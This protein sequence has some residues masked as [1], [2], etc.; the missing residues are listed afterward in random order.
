L[1]AKSSFDQ[2]IL[3]GH[4]SRKKKHGILTILVCV[5]ALTVSCDDEIVAAKYSNLEAARQ[6]GAI[7]KGWLPDNLPG[8]SYQ[9]REVHVIDTGETWGEV[10]FP[11]AERA[12]FEKT[13]LQ[14]SDSE[15][16]GHDLSAAPR[17][18]WW[19]KFLTGKLRAQT[20]R[21]QGFGAYSSKTHVFWF[22]VSWTDGHAYFW[23]RV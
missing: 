17:G 15:L 5:I 18:D 3:V 16:D 19:P 22:A 10:R 9:V 8:G 21:D 20:L 2:F 6:A 7:D 14:A 1:P 23:Q 13:L 11:P 4:P 12:E